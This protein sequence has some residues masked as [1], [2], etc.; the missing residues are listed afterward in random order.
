MPPFRA[1]RRRLA[2]D[3]RLVVSQRRQKRERAGNISLLRELKGSQ[4]FH[5]HA[6]RLCGMQ[7]NKR[8]RQRPR[9]RVPLQA[10]QFRD[11]PQPDR[12]GKQQHH[13]GSAAHENAED[14]EP[15]Q[16]AATPWRDTN[17]LTQTE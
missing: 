7:K 17:L 5:L 15:E 11:L 9:A 6:Q 12:R 3:I 2:A 16:L 10:G 4:Q 1:L 14:D 8:A 13:P